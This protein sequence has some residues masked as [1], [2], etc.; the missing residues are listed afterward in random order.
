MGIINE[1]AD[2]HRPG[3]HPPVNPLFWFTTQ[4]L[5][6]EMSR[7]NF[8]AVQFHTLFEDVGAFHAKMALDHYDRGPPRRLTNDEFRYR[9]AFLNEELREFIEMYA[10]ND[11]AGQV[12]ALCDLVWVALGTAQLMRVPFDQAW[13]EVRRSNMEKRPWVDGDPIKPRNAKG[14]EVVKPAGWQP[15][16]IAT[17]IM[18]RRQELYNKAR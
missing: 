18:D 8:I 5:I 16:Q 12:D 17:V 11:L 1:E 9:V 6:T 4:A 7:R 13:A 3:N 10:T 15:P 14:L 2:G